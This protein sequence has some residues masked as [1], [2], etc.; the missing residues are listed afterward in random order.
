MESNV[1]SSQLDLGNQLT[2]YGHDFTRKKRAFQDR[3]RGGIQSLASHSLKQL[4]LKWKILANSFQ[5]S[6]SLRGC[7]FQQ[8]IWLRNNWVLR[9]TQCGWRPKKSARNFKISR[10]QKRKHLRMKKCKKGWNDNLKMLNDWDIPKS[11]GNKKKRFVILLL[12]RP[13]GNIWQIYKHSNSL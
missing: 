1:H 3:I 13:W 5:A 12:C 9:L 8:N 10:C 11:I 2:A 4:N 6:W 7:D